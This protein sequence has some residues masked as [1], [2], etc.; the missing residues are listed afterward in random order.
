MTTIFPATTTNLYSINTTTWAESKVV[1]APNSPR[2]STTY[3]ETAVHAVFDSS[4]STDSS[5]AST[6]ST[7]TPRKQPTPAHTTTISTTQTSLHTHTPSTH[8]NTHTHIN[9]SFSMV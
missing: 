7:L 8:S 4:A 5:C 2:V 9:T 3:L 1:H 6:G